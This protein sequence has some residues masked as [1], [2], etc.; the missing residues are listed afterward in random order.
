MRISLIPL[1]CVFG[2]VLASPLDLAAR[3]VRII[4]SSIKNV[5][6]SLKGLSQAIK[7]LDPTL[8]GDVVSKEQNIEW[9]AQ[10]VTQALQQGTINV[11]RGPSVTTTE[12]AALLP[13]VES[14]TLTTQETINTWI[15]AKKTIIRSGGKDAVLRILRTQELAADEFTDAL[16]SKLPEIIKYAGR[17]YGQRTKTIMQTAITQYRV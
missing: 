5:Q 9:R 17:A 4:D 12:A 13:I 15:G 11:R 2:S 14:L 7:A 8:R 6:V 10:A 16:L 3:D 1:V